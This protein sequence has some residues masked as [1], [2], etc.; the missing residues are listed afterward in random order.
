VLLAH[1]FF[2]REWNGL[3]LSDGENYYLEVVVED[4]V[5]SV[6]E[7]IVTPTVGIS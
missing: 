3:T 7:F 4:A 2:V 1:G 6:E 5:G